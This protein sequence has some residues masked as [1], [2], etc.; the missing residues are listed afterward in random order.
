VIEGGAELARKLTALGEAVAGD[1][2]AAALRSGGLL[3][4]ADAKR[5]APYR[6]G[7]LRRSIHTEVDA[8]G[9]QAEATV[10]TDVP[11]GA[12]IE[13]GFEGKDALGRQYHQP[14]RPYL[15]PALDE[16][17]DAAAR[18]IGAALRKALEAV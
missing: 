17:M 10:G 7:T 3:V 18:E 1:V 14:A 11:Y 6:T 15:R 9:G 4:E 5:R 13:F 12:R 2:L 16:N 8:G